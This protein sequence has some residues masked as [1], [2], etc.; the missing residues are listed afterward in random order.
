MGSGKI[1]K[2]TAIIQKLTARFTCKTRDIS[3]IFGIE[4]AKKGSRS[5]TTNKEK[6]PDKHNESTARNNHFFCI[7]KGYHNDKLLSIS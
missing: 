3:N 2:I 4:P 6:I 7:K 1:D 5:N